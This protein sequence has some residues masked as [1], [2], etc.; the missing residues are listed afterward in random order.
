MPVGGD[1]REVVAAGYDAAA[2][3]YAQWAAAN[4]TDG[5]R[6]TYLDL[7]TDLLPP[8]A[9]VLELGC[10][11]GGS[12]TQGL[13]RDFRLTGVDISAGQVARARGHVPTGTFLHEDMTR[14]EFPPRSFDGVAA[15]YSLIHLP[16]GELPDMLA[17]IAAWLRDGGLF[18][19]SFAARG[20]GEHVEANWLGGVPMYWSGYSVADTTRFIDDAGLVSLR[21]SV[22]TNIEDGEETPFMW[23][24]ARAPARAG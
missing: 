16:H 2:D 7:F 9:S 12:T 23:V 14:V 10:G 1:P 20:E 8:S 5:G 4:V 19:A 11:G 21:S 22:E 3:E 6:A 13:A 24:L 18:V 15:F 17:R